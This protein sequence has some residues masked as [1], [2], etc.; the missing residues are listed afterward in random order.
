MAEIA[1]RVVIC[2]R[3]VSGLGCRRF[4]APQLSLDRQ[5]LAQNRE[6]LFD[7]AWP[8]DAQEMR[9]LER[10]FYRFEIYANIFGHPKARPFTGE[11]QASA[12]FGRF[13]PWENEQLACVHYHLMQLVI[14]GP[15]RGFNSVVQVD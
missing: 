14:P 13:S 4:C 6:P 5:N 2:A 7:S 8:I 10:A 15:A 3:P 9:R 12:F 11:E 1:R